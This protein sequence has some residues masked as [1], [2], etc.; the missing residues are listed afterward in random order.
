MADPELAATADRL[1]ADRA[2]HH[3]LR[4]LTAR[5]GIASLED[6]YRVQD[7]LLAGEALGGWKIALTTPVMQRL[8]GVDHPCEGAIPAALIRP[9]PAEIAAADHVHLAVEAEI[10]VRMKRPVRDPVAD[11]DSVA[12]AVDSC[13]AAIEIVDD[14][15]IPYETL[16]APTLIADNAM[17]YGCVLGSPVA[18]WQGLDLARCAGSM[19]VNGDVVGTG[20]GG[21]VMGHPFEALAWLARNL[22]RRERSLEAGD[23]VMTGSVVKTQWPVAGD[24]IEATIQGLGSATLA[25]T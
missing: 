13:M 10:A 12:A 1:R 5:D 23:I 4:Q 2:A 7:L 16:D 15:A 24:R 25:V 20:Q 11:R 21:D 18:D 22:V 17:N 8:V 6:A 19:R 3:P 9:S 14:R